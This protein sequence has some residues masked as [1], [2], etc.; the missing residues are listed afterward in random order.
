MEI[1]LPASLH[2]SS[3]QQEEAK[4]WVLAISMD[5]KVEQ[6]GARIQVQDVSCLKW[7]FRCAGILPKG[8]TR[9]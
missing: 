2:I 3:Q 6:V 1:P 5:Q 4:E 9:I 8:I 7:K